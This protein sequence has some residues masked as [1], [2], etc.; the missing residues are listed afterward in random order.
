[1]NSTICDEEVLRRQAGPISPTTGDWVA[2]VGTFEECDKPVDMVNV[3]PTLVSLC[4]L[5][6]KNILDGHD[7]TPLLQLTKPEWDY[8]ALTE[9]KTGNK[10]F[11][12][13]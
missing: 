13:W 3:F 1:M 10:I 9:I 7:M 12:R 11:Y 6:K 8:P 4:N 5:P 2:W